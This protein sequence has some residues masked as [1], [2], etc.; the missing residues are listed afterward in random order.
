MLS[1]Q[2]WLAALETAGWGHQV[3]Q[4]VEYILRCSLAVAVLGGQ[5]PEPPTGLAVSSVLQLPLSSDGSSCAAVPFLLMGLADKAESVGGAAASMKQPKQSKQASED[6]AQ[7]AAQTLQAWILDHLK[8]S[9]AAAPAS[10]EGAV[11]QHLNVQLVAKLRHVHGQQSIIPS[12]KDVLHVSTDVVTS[13][14]R[15]ECIKEVVM[16]FILANVLAQKYDVTSPFRTTCMATWYSVCKNWIGGVC[17]RT[18]YL[19]APYLC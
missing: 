4:R 3:Q 8:P 7:N 9:N 19:G 16:A 10:F 17:A 1:V 12:S 13:L 5:G 6:S 11:V 15:R 2:R 18:L 14:L